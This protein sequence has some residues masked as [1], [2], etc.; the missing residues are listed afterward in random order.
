M[1]EALLWRASAAGWVGALPRSLQ[2]QHSASHGAAVAAA[3]PLP[4]HLTARAAA[5]AAGDPDRGWSQ[6]LSFTTAPAVG[7]P[8]ALPYRLGLIG[9]LGQ[10]EHSV[11]WVQ[12]AVCSF[13][14]WPAG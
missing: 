2:A 8:G 5:P 11:R 12:G 1:S 13:G 3:A 6:E 10:S 7:S 4:P 9:D 14:N